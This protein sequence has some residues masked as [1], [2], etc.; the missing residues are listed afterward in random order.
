MISM[1]R[2]LI[3]KKEYQQVILPERHGQRK[4]IIDKEQ[5]ARF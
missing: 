1:V 3:E 4:I 2:I 5:V